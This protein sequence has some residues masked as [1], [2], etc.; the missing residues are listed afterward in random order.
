ML[1][2][3]PQLRQLAEAMGHEFSDLLLLRDALTHRSFANERPKLARADNERLEFLGDAVLALVVS[4]LLFERYPEAREGE[5]TRRRADLVCEASLE[6]VARSIDLGPLL[7]LGN[8]E[9]RS[10]GREK[11]RLL[12]S[13]LEACFAAVYL[14]GGV[15]AAMRVGRRLL[16][17][18]IDAAVAGAGDFKSR[19]QELVQSHGRVAPTY[20]LVA[21]EGP[22]HDRRFRVQIEVAGR[23]R[24]VG[25]GRSKVEA[26]QAAAKE[27]FESLA[28]EAQVTGDAP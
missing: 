26:E 9:E 25:Q 15:D 13:A 22:D 11:P 14:D 21:I 16:A 4:T 27:A 3:E 6:R 28:G 20:T 8:G 17:D 19:V 1:D 24:G 7:R 12:A 23:V 2:D 5:L 10:G 18:R